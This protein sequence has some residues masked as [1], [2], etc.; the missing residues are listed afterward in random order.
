MGFEQEQID[1]CTAK[2]SED[3]KDVTVSN[4]L[5]ALVEAQKAGA[6]GA[7]VSC[8]SPARGAYV[9][10]SRPVTCQCGCLAQLWKPIPKRTS[11][12]SAWTPSL[13]GKR[14]SSPNAV[15]NSISRAS[16]NTATEG[17][18]I[19]RN[20]RS[21]GNTCRHRPAPFVAPGPLA[22]SKSF[23]CRGCAF[24][25][26]LCVDRRR[27]TRRRAEALA[28]A[29][30]NGSRGRNEP[31]PPSNAGPVGISG[32]APPTIHEWKYDFASKVRHCSPRKILRHAADQQS[33]EFSCSYLHAGDQGRS[34][35][36][37]WSRRCSADF[38]V[39]GCLGQRHDLHHSFGQSI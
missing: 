37:S 11:A 25:S 29:A 20:A 28:Q 18:W 5:A 32:S 4:A 7:A 23:L 2:L 33:S 26:K 10:R 30:R 36:L 6:S 8:P 16:R 27:E 38:N 34:V 39:A 21:A 17:T 35:Q 3:G 13:S 22:L 1:K 19:K 24:Q 9:V 14:S 15:T 12:A 31:E